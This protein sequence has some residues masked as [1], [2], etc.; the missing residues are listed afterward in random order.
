MALTLRELKSVMAPLSQI[1]KGE[2]TFDIEGT[3]IC[4][5]A[6]TPQEELHVQRYARAALAEGDTGDQTTVMEYLD[7]FRY[8]SLGYSIV[9]IGSLDFRKVETIE[10]GEKLP[11]GTPIKVKKHEAL[12]EVISTWS[13]NMAVAVFRKF[14]ELSYRV[15]R[16]VEKVIVFE[17][18]DYDAEITRLEDRLADLKE[19]KSRHDLSLRDPRT[20]ARDKVLNSGS[21]KTQEPKAPPVSS[22]ET[23]PKPSE[24]GVATV[25]VAD[26]V[27]QIDEDEEPEED[28][29]EEA[30]LA[31]PV[32]TEVRGRRSVFAEAPTRAPV[33][34]PE[35]KED[36]LPNVDS[37]FGDVSNPD[38]LAAE[39]ARIR[40][41]RR[42]RAPHV[43]AREAFEEVQRDSEGPVETLQSQPSGKIG[44]VDVYKMPTQNL[45]DRKP[46]PVRTPPGAG[47]RPNK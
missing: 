31:S 34:A 20:E 5:R 3:A 12:I 38:V 10:T 1:G 28:D 30:P 44:G 6:L 45:S 29:N 46:G 14:G 21:S 27:R 22:T 8:M 35:T 24:G 11:N 36:L 33:A 37:S 13:R 18:V 26:T 7:R 43:S 2:L 32:P 25:T 15:E 9:Q 19:Q 17:E 40:E 41:M 39:E 4:L 23:F 16:D 47:F 42:G